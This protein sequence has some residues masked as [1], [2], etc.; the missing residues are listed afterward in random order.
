MLSL[1]I[2]SQPA[3]VPQETSALLQRLQQPTAAAV[4]A[5]YS[6]IQEM[7]RFLATVYPELGDLQNMTQQP[8]GFV[9]MMQQWCSMAKPRMLLLLESC[10]H[11]KAPSQQ[12]R[13][14]LYGI[15]MLLSGM[16]N[17]MECW[18]D[19]SA[20]KEAVKQHI[21]QQITGALGVWFCLL[22][23]ALYVSSGQVFGGRLGSR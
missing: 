6:N 11:I 20:D 4:T 13:A 9:A 8:R 19:M 21:A 15:G 5:E 12:H 18:V 7:T 2:R 1:H 22:F 17:L 3:A 23:V 10:A 16:A 14:V